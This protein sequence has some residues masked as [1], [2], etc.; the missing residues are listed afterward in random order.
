[1]T[2]RIQVWLERDVLDRA[3]NAMVELAGSWRRSILQDTTGHPVYSDDMP[4]MK[5]VWDLERATERLKWQL[6][7][8]QE[9]LGDEKQFEEIDA[10]IRE[11]RQKGYYI[12]D[13]SRAKEIRYLI[14]ALEQDRQK[15]A[16]AFAA[17]VHHLTVKIAAVKEIVRWNSK[18]DPDDPYAGML[19]DYDAMII[20]ALQ[21]IIIDLQ[22]TDIDNPRNLEYT[23]YN[24]KSWDFRKVAAENV[25]LRQEVD[26]LKERLEALG[27]ATEV[28][29]DKSQMTEDEIPF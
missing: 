17:L 11:Y 18:I 24:G 26:Q 10:L 13:R 23:F 9:E 22:E 5:F 27:Q 4:A 2:N 8:N 1:M 3:Y 15:T 14:Q 25:I 6:D 16:A 20:S 28:E 19:P 7:A 21:N 12:Q 29:V